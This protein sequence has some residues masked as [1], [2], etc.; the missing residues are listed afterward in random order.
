MYDISQ[1]PLYLYSG[2][3]TPSQVSFPGP[4]TL[5]FN[6]C[7]SQVDIISLEKGVSCKIP[8]STNISI[9]FCQKFMKLHGYIVY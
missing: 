6:L 1:N 8:I 5:L 7:V 3:R 9:S 4:V 2:H